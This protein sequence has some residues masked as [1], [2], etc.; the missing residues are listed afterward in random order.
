MATLATFGFGLLNGRFYRAAAEHLG[1][2]DHV[3]PVLAS[4]SRVPIWSLSGLILL[5]LFPPLG[6]FASWRPVERDG[7]VQCAS[8]SA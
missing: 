3:P 7:Y 6:V 4:P 5:V 8:Y 2:L 1:H